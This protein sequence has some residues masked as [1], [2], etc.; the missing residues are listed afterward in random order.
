MNEKLEHMMMIHLYRHQNDY[1]ESE[2][3]FFFLEYSFFCGCCCY[4]SFFLETGDNKKLN[5]LGSNKKKCYKLPLRR[6]Y[7][8]TIL[9]IEK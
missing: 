8:I 7:L 6:L 1:Y 5:Q 4:L 3:S 9:E 2:I